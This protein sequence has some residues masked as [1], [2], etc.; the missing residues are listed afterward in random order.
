MMPTWTRLTVRKRKK[1]KEKFTEDKELI[2]TKTIWTRSAD[3]ISSDEYI[4]FHKSL[5]GEKAV[6]EEVKGCR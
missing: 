6:S 1:I 4:E 2:K 5:R 3:D